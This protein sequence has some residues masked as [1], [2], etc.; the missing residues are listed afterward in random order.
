M[1]V[2][3]N[4]HVLTTAFPAVKTEFPYAVAAA[5]AYSYAALLKSGADLAYTVYNI[6]FCRDNIKSA[7]PFYN[8][9]TII[10]HNHKNKKYY[11]V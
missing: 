7:M 5:A 2:L 8:L 10:S 6:V 3:L 9:K 11:S 4:W 1:I